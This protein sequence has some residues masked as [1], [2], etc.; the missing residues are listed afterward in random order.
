M[1]IILS[2]LFATISFVSI[3]TSIEL[4]GMVETYS[5]PKKVNRLNKS[6]NIFLVLSILTMFPTCYFICQ[7]LIK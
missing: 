1:N 3:I 7:I 2:W 5:T 6:A 4:Q